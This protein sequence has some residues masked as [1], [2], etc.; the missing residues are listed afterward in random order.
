MSNANAA[1][2]QAAVAAANICVAVIVCLPLRE[3]DGA[4]LWCAAN[5]GFT[6][7]MALSAWLKW[8]FQG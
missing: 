7:G 2:I 6:I 8:K 5:A 1:L 4:R 3:G